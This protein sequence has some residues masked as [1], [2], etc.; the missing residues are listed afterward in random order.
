VNDRTWQVASSRAALLEAGGI[1]ACTVGRFRIALYAVGEDIFATADLCTHGGASLSQG[2]L[3]DYSIECPLHQGRF[4]I[5]TGAAVHPPCKR[6]VRVFPVRLEGESILVGI[7]P[8]PP[9][10]PS[11]T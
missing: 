4:D 11:P 2:F 8:E 10:G 7:P 3:E 6:A 9:P 5:R 1:I